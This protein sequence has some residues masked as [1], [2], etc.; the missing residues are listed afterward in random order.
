MQ[1]RRLSASQTSQGTGGD[2]IEARARLSL[3][4][5]LGQSIN[6]PGI[7]LFFHVLLVSLS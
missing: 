4:Q 5:R 2:N 1:G 3:W 7:R 6:F